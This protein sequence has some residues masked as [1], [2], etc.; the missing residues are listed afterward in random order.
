MFLF[1][2]LWSVKGSFS[3]NTVCRLGSALSGCKLACNWQ[4]STVSYK[5]RI[6]NYDHP[7]ENLRTRSKCC[8]NSHLRFCDHFNIISSQ[9]VYTLASFVKLS[10]PKKNNFL[11]MKSSTSSGLTN[12]CVCKNIQCIYKI[13]TVYQRRI[14]VYWYKNM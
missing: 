12:C 6:D 11:G 3:A 5:R 13:V 8:L 9:V 4:L 2:F 7:I 14:H 10:T 1:F